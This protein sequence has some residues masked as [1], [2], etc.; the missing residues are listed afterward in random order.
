ML[1]YKDT[2]EICFPLGGIGTGSIG[3]SGN[4]SLC[5]FEIFNRPFRKTLNGF[6]H[7][8]VKAEK[9]G[10]LLDFRVLS[11][12]Y[13]GSGMGYPSTGREPWVY[14]NGVSRFSMAGVAHF[15]KAEF[16]ALFPMAQICFSDC[17]FPG[18]ITLRALSPF[19]PMD[20]DDSS[21]PAAFFEYEIKN[22]TDS[23]LDCTVCLSLDN[24]FEGGRENR[25]VS[26]CG[27]D[28]V[29]MCG[30]ADKDS[31]KYGEMLFLPFDGDV[32]Y[33]EHWYRGGW[34]DELTTFLNDMKRPGALKNRS[35]DT[36]WDGSSDMASI[37]SA[38]KIPAGETRCFRFIICWYTPNFEKYWSADKP[39]W[40]NYSASLFKSAGH[41][42]EYCISN[43]ERLW[44]DTE[45]FKKALEESSLPKCVT[46]AVQG[47]L[48]ILKSTACTRLS[49]GTFWGW[50]GVTE[51]SG[52]CE[53][54]C[55]HVWNYAVALAYLFP[56]LERSIREAEYKYSVRDNGNM[57]FRTMVPL[58]TA[59]WNFRACADGQFGT[60][61]KTYREWKLCGKREFL[62]DKWDKIKS[63]IEW[64]WSAENS[65]RWDEK[66]SGVLTGRQHHTLDM[67]L[68]GPSAWLEGFYLA[69]LKA[70]AE[71]AREMGEHDV[72][73][74]YLGLFEKGKAWTDENLWNGEYF[75]QQIDIK[76]K[77][78]V[79]SYE[80]GELINSQ[81]YWN[82]E[83]GEICYQ[84]GDGC[85]IDQVTAAWHADL[86]GLGEIFD[87]E[88]R[89]KA[90][91]SIYKYNF[92]SMRDVDNPCRIFCFEDEKGVIMCSWDNAVKPAIPLTY[93]EEVMCGF[94][95]A[96]ACNM[97]QCGMEKE[98]LEIVGSVRARY[99]GGRRNPFAELECGASYARSMASYSL[100]IAYSGFTCDMRKGEIGFSPIHDGKYF[101]SA[102]GAWGTAQRLGKK[103][104]IDVLYGRITLK[105]IRFDAGEV[106]TVN[107]EPIPFEYE[108][109]CAVFEK[110]ELAAGDVIFLS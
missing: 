59:P 87:F 101:W 102:D 50:E 44:G 12:K 62:A 103:L 18:E 23:E 39:V 106:L 10:E 49:D 21:I 27:R 94:E 45:L 73:A 55:T 79:D 95:Y 30:G 105:Q 11:G 96:L 108:E 90:L 56:D 25:R 82:S 38:K 65:D 76:D 5:D 19:I 9:D 20:S 7:F 99:D 2:K 100:L 16:S 67:E 93:A 4:G 71:M 24:P 22:T 32:S 98:A 17:R 84:I 66:C 54:T 13:D 69:A 78:V 42:A 31:P 97:I 74:K 48:T 75:I 109:G 81:G 104:K 63:L 35:Y 14:G 41:I 88:K 70:G 8:A 89:K 61:I 15:E 86:A 6:S 47:N 53:G 28:A 26:V 33:Q 110:T 85:E 57:S 92:K 29:C 40:K 77:S 34:F 91:R 1:K 51:R 60:V 3:L 58:G 107:N 52:S 80:L 72:E 43:F 46:D 64:A 37:A 36:P 83:A 68:F